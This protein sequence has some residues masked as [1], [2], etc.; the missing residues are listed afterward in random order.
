ME[1]SQ[2][3][4]LFHGVGKDVL[5]VPVEFAYHA[6]RLVRHLFEAGLDLHRLKVEL[7]HDGDGNPVPPAAS[8]RL[9]AVL[10]G[11]DR[12]IYDAALTMLALVDGPEDRDEDDR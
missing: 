11:L 10:D 1:P 4:R 12:V 6:D 3:E 9:S 8:A 2:P 7:T 5:P